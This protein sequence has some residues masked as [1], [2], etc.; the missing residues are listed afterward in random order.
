MNI[1]RIA[2]LVAVLL[3]GAA[4]AAAD[5]LAAKDA[6]ALARVMLDEL[7][8]AKLDRSV[9]TPALSADLTD[10]IRAS[11]TARLAPF[12]PP[13][14]PLVPRSKYDSDGVTTYVFRIHWPS[15]SIDYIFG[16]DDATGKIAKLY[17]VP[18]P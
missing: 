8:S 17:F 3:A 1:A 12:G 15:G 4:P 2:L 16:I 13:R 6:I 7:Q 11:M 5:A 18:G 14:D 10:P 9:L